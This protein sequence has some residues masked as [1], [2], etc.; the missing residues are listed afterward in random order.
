MAGSGHH[1]G[2]IAEDEGVDDLRDLQEVDVPGE[3]DEGEAPGAAG[4]DERVGWAVVAPYEF[5][6]Q[7]R[8]TDVGE[9]VDVAAYPGRFIG[10]GYPGGQD[11]FAAL[12]EGGGVRQFGDVDPADGAVEPGRAGGDL[13]LSGGQDGKGQ[14]VGDGERTA[15]TVDAPA[16]CG[17]V[18][19]VTV[20]A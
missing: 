20:E 8:R 10:Q 3:R 13:G 11:E 12:A 14:G 6:D 19:A 2:L 1:L 15:G 5:D 17:S 9:F 18:D 7:G 16:G 4:V